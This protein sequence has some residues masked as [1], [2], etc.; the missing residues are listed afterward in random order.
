[1]S[2]IIH[3]VVED[4]IASEAGV[5]AGDRLLQVNGEPLL[6]VLDYQYLVDAPRLELSLLRGE[7]QLSLAVELEPGDTLGLR[8]ETS[9]FDGIRR[10]R[11][12]CVFCFVDQLPEDVRQSLK[13]KDD[14]YRLSFLYGNFITL[15]NLTKRDIERIKKLRLSP[16]YVSLHTLNPRLHADMLRPAGDD[17][18][19]ETFHD[20]LGSGI[21]MH[22]QIVLCPGLNDGAELASTLEKLAG[23]E[24]VASVGIVPVGLTAHRRNLR[25]LRPPNRS[26]ALELVATTARLQ[27]RMVDLRGEPWVYLADEF[28]AAHGLPLPP[29]ERY[30]DFPQIENG[31]G[32]ARAFLEDVDD[33]LRAF[34]GKS[35]TE[36]SRKHRTVLTGRLAKPYLDEAA[37]RIRRRL[38]IELEVVPVANRF[39]GES[40]TV[41]GLVAGAD[42]AGIAGSLS[43]RSAII[44]DIMLND[45]GLFVDDMTPSDVETLT[46]V[47]LEIVPS[48]GSGFVDWV[49]R[50][51]E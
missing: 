21:R 50:E 49:L 31:I 23:L 4:S 48:D 39:L 16:L 14:D 51:G 10:C 11:N 43:A 40:V 46:G 37:G 30:A 26:E 3:E 29:L 42:I 24:G 38:G 44:P 15:T 9:L 22:V 20:L 36:R 17:L 1:M 33:A 34:S 25:S 6:D 47:V 5:R 41:A 2:G 13:V 7:E 19:I 18:A 27:E 28:Y 8:F 35:L 12:D 45:D 32:L